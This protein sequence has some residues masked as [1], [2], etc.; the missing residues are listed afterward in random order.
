MGNSW[1]IHGNSCQKRKEN[2]NCHELTTKR[3]SPPT[4]A[5]GNLSLIKISVLY[6]H[7]SRTAQEL[8]LQL[9]TYCPHIRASLLAS[10]VSISGIVGA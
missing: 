3:S 6:S 8:I 1:I 5:K 9:L 2:M 4:G 7:T 10:L